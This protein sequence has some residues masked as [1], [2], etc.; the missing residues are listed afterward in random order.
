[1][2]VDK[3]IEELAYNLVNY[4]CRLKKGEKVLIEAFDIDYQ[5]VACIV[6]EAFKVGA[7]PFVETFNNRITR[8]LLIGGD[9]ELFGY[10]CVANIFGE[11]SIAISI[12]YIGCLLCN[13]NFLRI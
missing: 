7:Y 6:R 4:S 11:P 2:L 12:Y 8:E 9:K 10:L 5:L 13:D 1:M 3:R